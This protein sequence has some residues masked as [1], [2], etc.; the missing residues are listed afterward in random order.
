MTVLEMI[1]GEYP[2]EE[3]NALPYIIKNIIDNK[4]PDTLC[5]LREGPTREFICY[6]LT[7]DPA[8]RPSAEA[9]REHTWFQHIKENFPVASLMLSDSGKD[10]F[11]RTLRICNIQI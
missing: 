9:L 7:R 11:Y 6:C 1:S 2:F 5:R 3:C 10:S 4:P 8:D